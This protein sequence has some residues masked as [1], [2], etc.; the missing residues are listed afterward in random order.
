MNPY[1]ITTAQFFPDWCP[2]EC[3]NQTNETFLI[4]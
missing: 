3:D 4:N 2:L 1:V